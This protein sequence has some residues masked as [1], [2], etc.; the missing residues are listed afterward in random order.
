MVGCCCKLLEGLLLGGGAV[1]PRSAWGQ[2]GCVGVCGGVSATTEVANM[3][4]R[5]EM[6]HEKRKHTKIK[7]LKNDENPRLSRPNPTG[8]RPTVVFMA[9]EQP[10]WVD[11][12]PLY[13]LG[14]GGRTWCEGEGISERGAA[15]SEFFFWLFLV[16][17]LAGWFSSILFT[18][19]DSHHALV[20]RSSHGH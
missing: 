20:R 8:A 9:R 10:P 4:G 11:A 17:C 13:Q 1:E 3:V 12:G 16:D 7:K 15:E 5:D 6:P 14:P 2:R 19:C 18:I